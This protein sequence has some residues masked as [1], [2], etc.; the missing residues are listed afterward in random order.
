MTVAP[1]R[2]NDRITIQAD[3]TLDGRA[4]G[5][6]FASE[7]DHIAV[8]AESKAGSVVALVETKDCTLSDGANLA[9]EPLNTVTLRRRHAARHAHR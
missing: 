1:A 8:L 7:V 2:P 9:G 6:P 5:V 3:G 4:I